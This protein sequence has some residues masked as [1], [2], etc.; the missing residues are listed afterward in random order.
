MANKQSLGED[1]TED[2]QGEQ[3]DKN[4][5]RWKRIQ[6]FARS[7]S[8][9][10]I[11]NCSAYSS[12]KAPSFLKNNEPVRSSGNSMVDESGKIKIVYSPTL[13]RKVVDGS[14][15]QTSSNKSYE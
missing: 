13:T 5:D 14:D 10:F 11:P 3:T 15:S 2:D 8:E 12:Y 9:A 7:N 6:K 1:E 4:L